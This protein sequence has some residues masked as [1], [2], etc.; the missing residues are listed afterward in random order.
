MADFNKWTDTQGN[1]R[2]DRLNGSILYS[3]DPN[4]KGNYN[5]RGQL[6]GTMRSISAPV[7]ENW[8]GHPPTAAEMQGITVQIAKDIY[9]KKY[10]D[11]IQG[12]KINSQVLAEFLADTKSSI[13]NNKAIQK[14]LN[15]IGYNV[16]EDG[17]IGA[18]TLEAINKADTAVLYEAHR[19]QLIKYYTDINPH[20]TKAWLRDLDKY[21]PQRMRND[22][23][24]ITTD[25]KTQ[26]LIITVI[27][28]LLIGSSIVYL[29]FK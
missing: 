21:Y 9:K 28:T 15:T 3:T 23:I 29:F 13:G 14:A 22:P 10:W 11:E 27:L 1:R 26:E 17:S 19:Q 25:N 12:D 20:Y 16:A 18:Q 6:V 4:D 24:F 5:S 8:I 7:Y 2:Y